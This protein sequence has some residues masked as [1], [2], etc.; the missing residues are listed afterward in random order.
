MEC[1]EKA[2]CTD[3]RDRCCFMRTDEV[4]TECRRSCTTGGGPNTTVHP[5]VCKTSE[6]CGDAG[7]CAE[8]TCNGFKLFVCG[9]P[10][11]CN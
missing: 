9:Q 10:A 5:Q 1:D 4:Q 11:G 8:K 7:A 6:E 3:Q 2:D